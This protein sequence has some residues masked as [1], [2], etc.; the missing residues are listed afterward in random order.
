M[1][2]AQGQWHPHLA[3][4]HNTGKYNAWSTTE[5]GQHIQVTSQNGV[6]WLIKKK[7]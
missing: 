2:R 7:C 6:H 5:M 3:R 1:L 4:L